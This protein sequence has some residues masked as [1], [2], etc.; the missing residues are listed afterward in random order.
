[1]ARRPAAL[2]CCGFYRV[3]LCGWLCLRTCPVVALPPSSF[4]Y[5]F[6]CSYPLRCR[7]SARAMRGVVYAWAR[8]DR[9]AGAFCGCGDSRNNS[10][11]C[12]CFIFPTITGVFWP[13]PCA[14]S[15]HLLSHT[16]TLTLHMHSRC[17]HVSGSSNI[18]DAQGA[19][20]EAE[21]YLFGD[22]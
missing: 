16:L 13:L 19:H 6:Y 20:L 11:A 14:C 7:L 22:W 18:L 5:F 2:P 4:A 10:L 3:S 17:V 1:M 15:L 9:C 21:R 8:W 12:R